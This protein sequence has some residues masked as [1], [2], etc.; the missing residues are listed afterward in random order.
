MTME[1][2]QSLKEKKSNNTHFH[3]SPFRIILA[4]L[5]TDAAGIIL[6]YFELDTYFIFLGFRFHLSAVIPF[7]ILFNKNSLSIFISGLRKP[8]FK[9]KFLPVWWL[10]ISL[11]ILMSIIYFMKR[12]TPGDPDYFYE[13]GLSSIFDYPLYLIW[14]FPQFCL[15]FVSLILIAG[16]NK[17]HFT[18]AFF[19]LV[20]LFGWEM[21][22]PDLKIN[23]VSFIPFLAIAILASFFLTRLQNIYWFTVIV[24]SSV[25]CIVLLFGSESSTV[26]NLFFAREYHSWEGFLKT[27]KDIAGYIIPAYFLILLIIVLFYVIIKRDRG[28]IKDILF[29]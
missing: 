22:P 23:P 6:R 2:E 17:Y 12:I 3:L 7:L 1:L 8:Y 26:I 11:L 24:F 4:I 19:V 13:F 18:T 14:N 15:L 28:D 9:K 5:V 21:I 20:F 16:S 29:R 25:W 10:L 27:G